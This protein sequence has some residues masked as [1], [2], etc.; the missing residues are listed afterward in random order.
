MAARNIRP[1]VLSAVYELGTFTVSELCH[2]AGL[3]D[4]DQAYSQLKQLKQLGFVE[5]KTLRATGAHAPLKQYR[6][7]SDEMRRAQFNQELAAYRIT[8]PEPAESELAKAALEDAEQGVSKIERT[9]S[10]LSKDRPR[11]A[12]ERLEVLAAEFETAKTNLDTARLEYGSSVSAEATPGH[13]LIRISERWRKADSR[14]KELQ[15]SLEGAKQKID[16]GQFARAVARAM[17]PAIL[18]GSGDSLY[19]TLQNLIERLVLEW[20]EA[21]R[22]PMEV[23]LDE[24]RSD[25]QHPFTPVFRNAVRTSNRDV[26]F[27]VFQALNKI[28]SPWWRF[29]IENACY[30]KTSKLHTRNWLKAYASVR[31]RIQ[32]GRDP[33]S[34]VGPISAFKVYSYALEK[35]TEEAYLDITQ[36]QCVSLVSPLEIGFLGASEIVRPTLLSGSTLKSLNCTF[37][38]PKDVL[39]TYG[40]IANEVVYWQ[41]APGLRVAACLGMWGFPL[42]HKMSKITAALKEQR[43]LLILQGKTPELAADAEAALQAKE[44]GECVGG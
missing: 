25:P 23:L 16:F 20:G 10:E 11:D 28:D 41:G 32:V 35:L 39:H 34:G 42:E 7:V 40:P 33:A 22:A 27:D 44:I 38:D 3:T 5:Q 26:L 36:G 4:R 12:S 9:V 14:R 8:P 37:L 19:N 6:L 18:V 43:G 30:I 17:S 13:P 31:D 24:I 21:Y 2:T 1:R 29:N 15:E